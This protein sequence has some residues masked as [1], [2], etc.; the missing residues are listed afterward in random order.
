MAQPLF[1]SLRL[2]PLAAMPLLGACSTV[3]MDPA[4]DVARQQ[5]HLILWATGLMLLIIVPV[6]ILTVLFA[7]RYRATNEDT[8]YDPD[9]DH[10]T[11]LELIIWSAPLV[12]IVALG[13]LTWVGTHTLDPYRPLD[14]LAEG[15]P[16]TPA[17][18]PLEVQVVSLDWKWLFIYPEQGIATVNELVV[19]VDR[20]IRFRMTSSS[21]M[22]TFWVPSMAGMIYTMAGMETRLHGVLNRTGKFEG[23]SGNYSGA[24]FSGMSFWTYAVPETRFASWAAN[25]RRQPRRLDV[26]TYLKLERPSERVRP[27]GFGGVDPR[28]F[29]RVVAMCVQPGTPCMDMS[30]HGMQKGVNNRAPRPGEA[31]GALT[32]EPHEKGSSP[33]LSAPPG[34][35]PGARDPGHRANR[36]LT[37]AL[38][39]RGPIA[40]ASRAEA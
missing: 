22:N 40:R 33:H 29:E 2:W 17:V 9:W 19:P 4:G 28:L 14:R 16:L 8:D 18:R 32:R 10:S 25:V 35:A 34:P 3:V 23:R 13:A 30:G 6:M 37:W 27:I 24:G 31:E 39:P 15:R 36:N 21:V 1:R 20:P 26:P 11:G 5:S 38:P 12:I 7:W